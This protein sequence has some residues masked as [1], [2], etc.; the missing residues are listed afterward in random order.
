[1]APPI[2]NQNTE[3][4]SSGSPNAVSTPNGTLPQTFYIDPATLR[5][6]ITEILQGDGHR[7]TQTSIMDATELKVT[8]A[9]IVQEETR[10]ALR[11]GFVTETRDNE[12]VDQEVDV[13]I[14]RE[15]TGLDKIPDVIK[16]LREFSGKTSEYGSWR[17]SVER[18]LAIYEHLKT[19]PKY[20]GILSIIRNKIVGDADIVLESYNTPLNWE[21]I[22]KCLNMHYSDKRDLT[23]LEYQMLRMSQK[24]NTVQD[25]YQEIYHHLSLILNKISSMGLGREAMEAMTNAYRDKALDAF[26]GGL[27]G[28][29]PLFLSTCER[30]DLPHALHLCEKLESIKSRNNQSSGIHNRNQTIASTSG[31]GRSSFQ[32]RNS[33]QTFGNNFSRQNQNFRPNGNFRPNYQ[34]QKYFNPFHKNQQYQPPIKYEPNDGHSSYNRNINFSNKPAIQDS[35][36]R[37]NHYSNNNRYRNNNFSN[38]SVNNDG[39]YNRVHSSHDNSN[40]R[41]QRVNFTEPTI[42]MKR[43]RDDTCEPEETQLQEVPEMKN[44]D[45]EENTFLD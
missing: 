44:Q 8:I 17:K 11:E 5:N 23:T 45:T 20:Y 14:D 37:N 29:L 36:Y 35:Q 21:K 2:P 34:Q 38:R 39:P 31:S 40:N 26:I 10:K 30:I 22:V 25:F 32:P 24:G 3:N 12:E 1:M 6:T 42:N 4:G 41:M 33:Y 18:I 7:L 19:T 16:C 13:Q 43:R 28:D 27:K 15:L 9:Q